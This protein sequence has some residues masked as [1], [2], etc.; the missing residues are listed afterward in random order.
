MLSWF[1]KSSKYGLKR[2]GK[3]PLTSL[4]DAAW[5]SSSSKKASVSKDRSE[6]SKN[7]SLAS[8]MSLATM[9]FNGQRQSS[10]YVSDVTRKMA[11]AEMRL[12]AEAD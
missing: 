9:L 10:G 12:G 1:G 4:Y 7:R 8:D 6:N 5:T 2:Y 3:M 11:A